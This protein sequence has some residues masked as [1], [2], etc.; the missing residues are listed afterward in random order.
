MIFEICGCCLGDAKKR[1][2]ATSQTPVDA[3]NF[4]EPSTCSLG[5]PEEDIAQ[6]NSGES[7]RRRRD[8]G[9]EKKWDI[10]EESKQTTT[11]LGCP[12]PGALSFFCATARAAEPHPIPSARQSQ[13]SQ[14]ISAGFMG[15]RC[16]SCGTGVFSSTAAQY[17]QPRRHLRFC[18]LGM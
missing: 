13:S 12:K 15:V 14:P 17:R 7:C 4:C 3:V 16:S 10:A 9:L 5:A 1:T 11:N 2:Q 6:A 18:L 8:D